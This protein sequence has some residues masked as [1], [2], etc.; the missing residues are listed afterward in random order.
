MNVMSRQWTLLFLACLLVQG[1]RH[2]RILQGK[3]VKVEGRKLVRWDEEGQPFLSVTV[4]PENRLQVR[5]EKFE[6]P[7]YVANKAYFEKIIIVSESMASS[8]LYSVP[9]RRRVPGEY[10]VKRHYTLFDKSNRRRVGL[11]DKE[12]V[13]TLSTESRTLVSVT[14]RTDDDGRVLLD[15]GELLRGSDPEDVIEV[16]AES[17]GARPG[18]MV[19][20]QR[21]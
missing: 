13:C 19:L 17:D 14:R 12:V 2:S 1:C 18:S 8:P 4:V 9:S 20:N 15:L 21:R 16:A 3:L 6:F 10:V 7:V 5:L 11:S